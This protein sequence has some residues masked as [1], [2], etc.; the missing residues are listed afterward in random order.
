MWGYNNKEWRCGCSNQTGQ[1][2][3][4]G[5]GGRGVH[6]SCVSVCPPEKSRGMS[7]CRDFFSFSKTTEDTRNKIGEEKKVKVNE[8]PRFVISKQTKQKYSSV[9]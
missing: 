6:P 5:L 3:A 7:D 9:D 1:V 2:R 8:V 4:E